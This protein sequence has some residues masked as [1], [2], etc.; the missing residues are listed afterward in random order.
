MFDGRNI[1]KI[2]FFQRGITI[3]F[4]TFLKIIKK[5]FKIKMVFDFDDAIFHLNFSRERVNEVIRI[6]D[7]VI[8]GSHY[9]HEYAMENNIKTFLVPTTVDTQVKYKYDKP[10]KN[11]DN[12]IVIGWIGSLTNMKYLQLLV[13]PLCNLAKKYPIELLI[14]G[15]KEKRFLP[16]FKSLRIDYIVWNNKTEI[17]DLLKID[18]GVM[19]L[20]DSNVEKGKCAFKAIQ[21][22][23]LGIPVVCSNIGENKYLIE[24]GANGF[25]ASSAKEWQ[26]KIELLINDIDLRKKIASKGKKTIQDRYSL[27]KNSAE[28]LQIIEQNL[29]KGI[30]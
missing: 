19:P 6:S 25:L 12:K 15:P 5:L 2:F 11:F 21:Y 3:G 9:L 20:F 23:A 28:L 18:I 29:F 4:V 13:E 22:M 10:I 30:A 17:N 27:E 7:I 24:E 26:K 1:N 16:N 14:I 8:A